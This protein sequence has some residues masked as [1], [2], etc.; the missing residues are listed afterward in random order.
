MHGKGKC[1]EK[2]L[3]PK[4]EESGKRGSVSND[5]E[6]AVMGVVGWFECRPD[7]RPGRAVTIRACRPQ[8]E[9]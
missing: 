4:A 9:G 8:K 1:G 3:S 5:T 2:R 7:A 6:R